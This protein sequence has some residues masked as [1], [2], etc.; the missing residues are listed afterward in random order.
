MAR[1]ELVAQKAIALEEKISSIQS[2]VLELKKRR[3]EDAKANEK[4]MSL[5][6]SGKQAWKAKRI[7][8]RNE[9]RRLWQ[10]LQRARQKAQCTRIVEGDVCEDCKQR[11]ALI[12]ELRERLGEQEF[13]IMATMEE[14][15]AEQ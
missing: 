9:H 14:A 7:K 2:E 8:S 4:V 11:Q 5:F 13:L 3:A 1:L 6:A 15:K 10:E 12:V